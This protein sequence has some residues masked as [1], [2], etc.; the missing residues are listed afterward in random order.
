VEWSRARAHWKGEFT[1]RWTQVDPER[2]R[3]GPA[4]FVS[5]N[6]SGSAKVFFANTR[7]LA[8]ERTEVVEASAANATLRLDL[9]LHYAWAVGREDTLNPDAVAD[10]ANGVGASNTI[11]VAANTD[12]LEELNSLFLTLDDADVNAQRVAGPEVREVAAH[13]ALLDLLHDVHRSLTLS[14]ACP[15]TQSPNNLSK[16]ITAAARTDR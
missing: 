15:T 9:D 4:N 14:L 2:E 6:S 8:P 7:L 11:I 13:F 16:T 3:S 12:A 5:K 1:R 10:L